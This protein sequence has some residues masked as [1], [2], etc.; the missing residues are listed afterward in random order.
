MTPDLG[1]SV[2]LPV[3]NEEQNIPVLHR[4]LLAV[5]EAM[6]QTFELLY[7]DDGSTDRS[8]D[9][10]RALAA[11]DARVKY[12]ALSRNFGHQMAVTAGLQN[13]RGLSVV[14][15]DADLQDPPELIPVLHG[16]YQ[17][18]YAVVYARR[19]SRR[20]EGWAKRL[21]ARLFYRVLARMT[22]IDIPLDVGDFRIID[23]KIVEVLRRMPEQHK[24]L[25]GQIAWAGFPQS[26][27]EYDRDE[28]HAGEPS[29]TYTRMMRFAVDG[30]TSFSD[31][32]LRVASIAGFAVSGIALLLILYAFYSYYFRE[33]IEPGWAST[34]V[35]LLFLGGVQLIGIGIIGEYIARMSANVRNRPEYV[36]M[37]TNLGTQDQNRRAVLPEGS[38]E[39]REGGGD[40]VER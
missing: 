26:F 5:L 1:I 10:V 39:R 27:V 3:H 2:I 28:R 14:I 24:F 21:T 35:S 7:V 9:L 17:E 19:R 15:M 13:C 18:G 25:R 29:Y 11:A 36:I 4:R 34:I 31:F 12:I 30:I 38:G 20:G 16:R 22:A 40:P 32:P 23:R 8:L 6:E 37:E 33:R